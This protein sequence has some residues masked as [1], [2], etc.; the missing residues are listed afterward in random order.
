M[1]DIFTIHCRNY[2]SGYYTFEQ[3]LSIVS[4]SYKLIP[5]NL[6]N[7]REIEYLKSS[8]TSL[9]NDI[10]YIKNQIL[11]LE[12]EKTKIEKKIKCIVDFPYSCE[13]SYY[14]D[15]SVYYG[16]IENRHR[17]GKGINIYPNGDKYEG[18]WIESIRNGDGIY[19]FSNGDKLKGYWQKNELTLDKPV[20]YTYASGERYEGY[21]DILRKKH[22]KGIAFFVN[23]DRYDGEF[24]DGKYHG[25]GVFSF[26]N[27][28]KQEGYWNE[29]ELHGKSLYTFA[30]G[31]RREYYYLYGKKILPNIDEICYECND[32]IDKGIILTTSFF[33]NKIKK[34]FLQL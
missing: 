27:G 5:S 26:A 4:D 18:E 10:E 21:L 30:N 16:E 34:K 3:F 29:N 12:R 7:Q 22:G 25:K 23:G 8:V 15:G 32:I 31:E 20:I 14:G 2:A 19:T 17:H 6:N 13:P 24:L 9:K 11:S 28:D 33:A 1:Q